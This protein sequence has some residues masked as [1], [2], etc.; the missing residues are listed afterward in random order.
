M[1][2]RSIDK[3]EQYVPSRRQSKI[4]IQRC[5]TIV[6]TRTIYT[7]DRSSVD[8]SRTAH[9]KYG[10]RS[11]HNLA[12]G[13]YKMVRSRNNVAAV[14]RKSLIIVEVVGIQTTSCGRSSRNE[15][16]KDCS[17]QGYFVH[18]SPHRNDGLS[19]SHPRVESITPDER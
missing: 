10:S 6:K 15:S 4:K 9:I 1:A 18:V 19:H 2:D 14:K 8:G 12:V 13:S 7:G 3:R 5:R 11:A 17:E 16:E